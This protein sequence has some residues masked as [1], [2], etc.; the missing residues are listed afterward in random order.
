MHLIRVGRMVVNLD[1]LVVLEPLDD[2]PGSADLTM[3][4]GRTYRLPP[5]V[6]ARLWV[7]VDQVVEEEDRRYEGRGGDVENP[8][9]LPPVEPGGSLSVRPPEQS[10]AESS[11]RSSAPPAATPAR[12][13]HRRK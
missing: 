6:A 5:G 7:R 4:G 11:P 8:P 1:F 3:A 10:L 13:R 9:P 12:P 2:P